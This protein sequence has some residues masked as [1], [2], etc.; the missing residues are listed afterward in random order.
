MLTASDKRELIERLWD[1]EDPDCLEAEA[2]GFKEQII[3]L[4][5]DCY[6]SDDLIEWLSRNNMCPAND[7]RFADIEEKADHTEEEWEEICEDAL[8]VNEYYACVRW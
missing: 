1:E 2:L 7:F 6:T 4:L 8:F 3:E 5:V